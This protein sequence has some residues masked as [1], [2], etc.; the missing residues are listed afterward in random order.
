MNRLLICTAV[1][2]LALV[3]SGARASGTAT[4]DMTGLQVHLVDL[5]PTD[6]IAPSVTF[7]STGGGSFVSATGGYGPSAVD[8][9]QA[10]ASAFSSLAVTTGQTPA[11]GSAISLDGDIFGSGLTMHGSAYTTG[12]QLADASAEAHLFR[13]NKDSD[14]LPFTLSAH[15]E[16][17]ISGAMSGTVETNDTNHDVALAEVNL[18]LTRSLLENLDTDVA[19]VTLRVGGDD[20]PVSSASAQEDLSVSFTN[21][22]ADETTGIFLGFVVAAASTGPA[23][24]L[25]VDEPCPAGLLM[26]G[27]AAVAAFARR[28]RGADRVA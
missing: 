18:V 21:D 28:K 19:G 7:D 4:I 27:A 25:S 1:S 24:V 5:D 20:G 8:I 6:G 10:G 16:L 23:A 2:A 3:G 13:L 15:T 22:S 17:V 11:V 26:A 12:E 9:T 14:E